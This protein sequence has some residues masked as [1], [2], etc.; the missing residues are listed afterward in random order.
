MNWHSFLKWFLGT[1][2]GTLLFLIAALWVV[3]PYGNLPGSPPF[4]RT[5]M[6]SN[7]RFSYPAVARDQ[8]FDSA[9][10]GTSTTRLLE[11]AALNKTLGGRFANLSMNSATFYEQARLFEVFRRAHEVP[12][13]VIIG[14]DIVW[15][16]SNAKLPKYTF[17][18]FPEWMY[19]ADPWNDL[20]HMF[21]VKSFEVLG[22]QAAYLLGL[23]AAK[24]GPDGYAN[25]LPP[26]SEYDLQKARKHIYGEKGPRPRIV[27][28][29]PVFVPAQTRAAWT[30]PSHADLQDMLASLPA[31]TRKILFFVPYHIINQHVRGTAGF[32]HWQECK[33]RVTRIVAPLDN[34]VLLDFMIES[35]L[36]S[37]DENYWDPLHYNGA[38]AE[39]VSRLIARGAE[40][41]Q[42]P[43]GEFVILDPM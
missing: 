1:L 22:R 6:A 19:D 42:A 38:V 13:T 7:Q 36:T 8:R 27:P 40:N 24:Y 2:A 41:G 33:D 30:Y 25:F 17:R 39:T 26:D 15:C 28:V 4:E 5:A 12:K 23:Q 9:V 32:A 18:R 16:S 31:E 37:R 20:A 21:E 3:D 34:A 29:P 10:V 43:S 14:L 11:P 35:P